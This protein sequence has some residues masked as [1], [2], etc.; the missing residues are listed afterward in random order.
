MAD[1]PKLK[2]E[3]PVSIDM[4]RV[5]P[6]LGDVCSPG[7]CATDCPAG[8]GNG[9]IAACTPVGSGDGNSCYQGNSASGSGCDS[10]SSATGNNCSQGSTAMSPCSDGGTVF[11]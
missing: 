9:S 6:V 2:Y 11:L 3:K 4:G 10:G 1:K 5:A 8:S 7:S